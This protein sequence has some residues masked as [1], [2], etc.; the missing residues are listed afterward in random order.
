MVNIRDKRE[1]PIIKT[2]KKKQ[3]GHQFFEGWIDARTQSS[4]ERSAPIK[5]PIFVKT[6]PASDKSL[7]SV[8][9]VGAAKDARQLYGKARIRVL[10]YAG[11]AAHCGL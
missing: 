10:I 5:G 9:A 3:L 11:R 8:L 6:R 7:L 4:H 2:K 1:K